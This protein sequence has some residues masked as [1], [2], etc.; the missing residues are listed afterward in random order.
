[1][2]KFTGDVCSDQGIVHM[3]LAAINRNQPDDPRIYLGLN[4]FKLFNSGITMPMI[5]NE[6]VRQSLVKKI[7]VCESIKGKPWPMDDGFLE[8]LVY[9][10]SALPDSYSRLSQAFRMLWFDCMLLLKRV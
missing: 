2:L 7:D 1:M 4:P 3:K 8:N 5:K 9:R 10:I 6:E